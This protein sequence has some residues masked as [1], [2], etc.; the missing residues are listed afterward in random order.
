[1]SRASTLARAIGSDGALN[2]A[3]VAGLAAVASSGSASDLSTGTLPIA[4]V[5]DG[6]V[7]NAKLASDLDA[8]KLASGTLPIARVAD[9]AVTA[10]KLHTTAVTDKLGYIPQRGQLFGATCRIGAYYSRVFRMG[11]GPLYASAIVSIAH[12]RN[13]VVMG[14]TWIVSG[15]HS[16]GARIAQI[17]GHYYT[18]GYK[19]AVESDDNNNWF[20]C[21]YDSGY[22]PDSQTYSNWDVC[23]V[24]LVGSLT[25]IYTSYTAGSAGGIRNEVSAGTSAYTSNSTSDERLKSNI[26]P[27]ENALEKVLQLGGYTFDLDGNRDAGMLAQQVLA[28]QP[29]FVL[30]VPPEDMDP[31]ARQVIMDSGSYVLGLKYGHM[32]GLFTEAIKELNSKVEA[33]AVEIAVLKGNQ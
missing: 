16:G 5:A 6:A 31:V 7:T 9:G 22:N 4:R 29:E 11:V 13:S 20:F 14:S 19:V 32:A 30:G 2:V 17:E 12:T 18:G 28:V 27:I 3:D 25:N 24:P 1:M 26:Q 8:S 21:I 23:V 33:Q 10:A 15:G